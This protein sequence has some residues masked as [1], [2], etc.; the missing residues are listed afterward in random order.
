AA[1]P[2]ASG[3]VAS[4]AGGTPSLRTASP[5]SSEVDQDLPPAVARAETAPASSP[6]AQASQVWGPVAISFAGT[7]VPSACCRRRLGAVVCAGSDSRI[8]L[9]PAVPGQTLIC[10]PFRR[11]TVAVPPVAVV[12]P[13]TAVGRLP[14]GR[15]VSRATAATTADSTTSSAVTDR[16]SIW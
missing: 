15:L 2:A 11:A 5:M 7:G 10:P 6:G 3:P 14:G 9:G 4:G 16:R 1:S 8:A 12:A 13:E